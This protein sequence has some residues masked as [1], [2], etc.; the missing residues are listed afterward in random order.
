MPDLSPSARMRGHVSSNCS[1]SLEGHEQRLAWVNGSAV[2]RSLYRDPEAFLDQALADG[3][4]QR[5]NLQALGFGVIEREAGI[6]VR[7]QAPQ[8]RGDGIEQFVQIQR[9]KRL[10]C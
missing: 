8:R 1:I 2:R 9:L 7:H 5:V 10:Y 6:F 4:I 3:K